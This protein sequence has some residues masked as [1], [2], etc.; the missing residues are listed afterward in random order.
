LIDLRFPLFFFFHP[1]KSHWTMGVPVRPYPLS[2]GKL[3]GLIKKLPSETAGDGGLFWARQPVIT[4]I[5]PFGSR[6][7]LWVVSDCWLLVLVI[8]GE[9]CIG[10]G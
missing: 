1:Y 4:P 2:Q 3:P 6:P 7:D 8:K 10:I 5:A 9:F